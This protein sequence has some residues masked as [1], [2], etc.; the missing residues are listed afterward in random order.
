M[1]FRRVTLSV[2]KAVQSMTRKIRVKVQKEFG[3][4]REHHADK[5]SLVWNEGHLFEGFNKGE[6]Y[7]V[8]VQ[9]KEKNNP[10]P[11]PVKTWKGFS[12]ISVTLSL[13]EE[14]SPE[15]V[16]LG[17]Q[18]FTYSSTNSEQKSRDFA[19]LGSCEKDLIQQVTKDLMTGQKRVGAVNQGSSLQSHS[20]KKYT[21]ERKYKKSRR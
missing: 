12:M 7:T 1:L 4:F 17:S 19:P 2:V 15:N 5:N 10:F 3:V 13:F 16:F 9:S 11:L 14:R 18:R 21:S 6:D 8:C 20:Y